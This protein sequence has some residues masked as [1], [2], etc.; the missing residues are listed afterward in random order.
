MPD[1]TTPI[2]LTTLTLS[3]GQHATRTDGVCL[4]EAVAWWAGEPHGDAPKCVSPVLGTFG[5]NLNDVLPQDM[6]QELVPLVP[7][8]AGTAGD[9][10][11]EAR[12][13][14]ALDW[15][16]RVYLPTWLE[17]GGLGDAAASV[18]GLPRIVDLESAGLAG[19]V[20]R[21]A[22]DVARAAGAVAGAVAW[23]AAWAAA[24][25][26][27]GDAARA[28]A[29]AADGDDREKLLLA[30]AAGD[31]AWAAARAADGDA[32]QPTTATL[33]TD[34]IRLLHNMTVLGGTNAR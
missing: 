29:R 30:V 19:P 18:R 20:V 33:Q 23:V 24:W 28:A 6:R 22:R 27:A 12:S 17:A 7:L 15:L 14:M 34:A 31:A 25:D 21:E 5:R 9:G 32:L 1:Q 13:Y 26:A 8:M 10:H 2:D 3:H 4:L 16:V 11:D